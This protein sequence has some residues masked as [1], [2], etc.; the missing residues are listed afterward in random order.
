MP[1]G[2]N[3]NVTMLAGQVQGAG[4]KWPHQTGS[5]WMNTD[6]KKGCIDKMIVSVCKHLT[7]NHKCRIWPSRV[8]AGLPD[9]CLQ[10]RPQARLTSRTLQHLG[11]IFFHSSGGEPGRVGDKQIIHDLLESLQE[12]SC[13]VSLW[14][15]K[16]TTTEVGEYL[17]KWPKTNANCYFQQTKKK[18]K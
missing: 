7:L 13:G 8:T 3:E 12:H 15:N 17:V 5:N 9:G 11:E 6:E 1:G 16:E 18:K 2:H 14:Y 4:D 10:K